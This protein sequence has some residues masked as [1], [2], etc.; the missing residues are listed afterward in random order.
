MV[1]AA[2]TTT[3]LLRLPLLLALLLAIP[4]AASAH[5]LDE[6]LQATLVLIEPGDVRLQINLTPGVEVADR[7]IALIDRDRDGTISTG[8]AAAYSEILKR[9]LVVRLDERGV[10]L[11]LTASDF[12]APAEFRT[13]MGIVKTE[14]SITP[15]SFTPGA[16][17]LTLD[18]HHLPAIGVYLFNAAKPNS[19]S[20]RITG[21]KRNPNQSTGAIEFTY[22]PSRAHPAGAFT[23]IG[24]GV[25]VGV[26]VLCL[27][28]GKWLLVR[29]NAPAPRY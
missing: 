25:G 19:E 7:V 26:L 10:D 14:F 3:S 23:A 22:S 13:G 5:V 17:R 2:V 4:R 6:Y 16:H 11:K 28:A 27:L 12:P 24:T 20:V 8:E 18:N 15:G 9:D 29:R 21:Q 1:E